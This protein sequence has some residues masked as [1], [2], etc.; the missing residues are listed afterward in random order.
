MLKDLPN[1]RGNDPVETLYCFY[2]DLGWDGEDEL[3]P[4]R[5]VMSKEDHNSLSDRVLSYGKTAAEKLGLAF[6]LLQKGPTNDTKV[7]VG[8]VKIEKGEL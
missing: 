1:F 6:L 3:E 4:E 8:K 5:I 2:S 7:P